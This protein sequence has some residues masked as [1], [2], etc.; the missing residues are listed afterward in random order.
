MNTQSTF[1]AMD[2]K[3]HFILLGYM[4]IDELSKSTYVDHQLPSLPETHKDNGYQRLLNDGRVKKAAN[5]L[6][7]TPNAFFP[8][9]TLNSRTG[10]DLCSDGTI[11]LTQNL[12]A[13]VDGQHR[14]RAAEHLANTDNVYKNFKIPVQ[15]IVGAKKQKECG[16]FVD[17]NI[18]QKKMDVA[19]ARQ[20]LAVYEREEGFPTLT[21][22]QRRNRI[23]PQVFSSMKSDTNSIWFRKLHSPNDGRKTQVRHR[24]LSESNRNENLLSLGIWFSTLDSVYTLLSKDEVFSK[25]G[26]QEQIEEFQKIVEGFW[27]LVQKYSHENMNLEPFQYIQMTSKGVRILH[28]VLKDIIRALQLQ[29]EEVTKDNMEQ[30]FDDFDYLKEDFQWRNFDGVKGYLTTLG[31]GGFAYKEFIKDTSLETALMTL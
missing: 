27:E 22:K 16:I 21:P 17:Q 7:D 12:L 29:N 26:E 4:T 15:I 6:R 11:L 8:C 23:I 3:S 18:N 25:Y 24:S 9:I 2:Q 10:I 5:Y 30:F 20:I 19:L 1:V 14:V 31:T 13:I 28:H